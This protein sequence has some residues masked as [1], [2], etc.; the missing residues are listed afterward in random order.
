MAFASVSIKVYNWNTI[1]VIQMNSRVPGMLNGKSSQLAGQ[2]R[3]AVLYIVYGAQYA[4]SRGPGY[5]VHIAAQ[6][7]KTD[8]KQNLAFSA[9]F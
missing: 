2:N 8:C 7:C 3:R 6:A 4:S 5:T 1:I 9:I